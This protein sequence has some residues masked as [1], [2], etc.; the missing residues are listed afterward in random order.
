MAVELLD[1]LIR[2]LEERRRDRQAEGLVGLLVD[3]ERELSRSTGMARGGT[4]LSGRVLGA[5]GRSLSSLVVTF[6]PGA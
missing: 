4:P 2:P 5:G 6:L 1:H 3:Q